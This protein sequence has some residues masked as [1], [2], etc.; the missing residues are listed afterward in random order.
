MSPI[1][2]LL[3]PLIF[4]FST[5]TPSPTLSLFNNLYNKN[6]SITIFSPPTA[7]LLLLSQTSSWNSSCLKNFLKILSIQ[8]SDELFLNKIFNS[9]DAV[10]FESTIFADDLPNYLLSSEDHSANPQHIYFSQIKNI[11]NKGYKINNNTKTKKIN[12]LSK[13]EN[14]SDNQVELKKK[15][16]SDELRDLS[17]NLL[18]I[19]V[20]NELNTY[21][22]DLKICLAV[23]FSSGDD[24]NRYS[25]GEWIKCF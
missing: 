7:Y 16:I 14:N 22:I 17:F 11:I 6:S 9:D 21:T 4:Q 24:F 3:I 10:Q 15:D 19:E 2:L 20:T 5:S 18:D 25:Y 12:D 1:H 13:M 8:F 23:L